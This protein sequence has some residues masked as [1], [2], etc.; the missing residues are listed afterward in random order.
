MRHRGVIASHIKLWDVITYPCSKSQIIYTSKIGQNYISKIGKNSR[1]HE[2]LSLSIA[3]QFT[4][5]HGIR[6]ISKWYHKYRPISRLWD[7]NEILQWVILSLK[8]PSLDHVRANYGMLKTADL[9]SLQYEF[10]KRKD[11]IQK[12]ISYCTA[13]F[14]L[15]FLHVCVVTTMYVWS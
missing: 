13:F 11:K 4:N 9:E 14:Y 1:S 3:L 15:T 10:I 6:Q 12:Y 8:E 7:F 2:I 5:H